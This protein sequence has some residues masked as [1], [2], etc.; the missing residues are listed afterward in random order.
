MELQKGDTRA[1]CISRPFSIPI[2]P[3]VHNSVLS[4]R[5]YYSSGPSGVGL[6]WPFLQLISPKN[7]RHEPKPFQVAAIRRDLAMCEERIVQE[8]SPEVISLI[9]HRVLASA[10]QQFQQCDPAIIRQ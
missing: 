7:A 10:S 1:E 8:K 2:L 9:S 4:I 5:V 3:T 6:V